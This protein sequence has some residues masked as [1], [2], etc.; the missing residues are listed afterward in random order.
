PAHLPARG[1]GLR[2][3][4]IQTG[5][6]HWRHRFALDVPPSSG[7]REGLQWLMLARLGV[8][9]FILSIIVLHQV[10][11]S[12]PAAPASL[13]GAYGLLVIAFAFNLVQAVLLDRLPQR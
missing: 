11:G 12:G 10:L 8:V 2:R 5:L 4:M 3:R 6:S 7:V 13:I 9:Y 1:K